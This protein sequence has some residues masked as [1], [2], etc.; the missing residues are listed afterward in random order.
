MLLLDVLKFF[1]AVVLLYFDDVGTRFHV[2]E[3]DD[4][5]SLGQGRD[6]HEFTIGVIDLDHRFFEFPVDLKN[7]EV[8]MF[9]RDRFRR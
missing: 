7:K 4:H 6:G 1:N 5:L 3:V 2:A 9:G 8:L